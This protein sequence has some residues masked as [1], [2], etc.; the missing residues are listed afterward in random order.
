MVFAAALCGAKF[1]HEEQSVEC[2]RCWECLRSPEQI[3]PPWRKKTFTVKEAAKIL[4]VSQ[5]WLYERASSEE[6]PHHKL[7]GTAIRF[8]TEDIDEILEESKRTKQERGEPQPRKK[9]VAPRSRIRLKHVK[10]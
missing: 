8:T 3:Q 4:S 10:I 5:S 9:S 2:P 1:F 6:I 7:G